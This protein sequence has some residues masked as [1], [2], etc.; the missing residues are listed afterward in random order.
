MHGVQDADGLGAAGDQFVPERVDGGLDGLGDERRAL[1]VEAAV[2]AI[3]SE[4]YAASQPGGRYSEE[5]LARAALTAALDAMTDALAHR[6]DWLLRRGSMAYS[7]I[8]LW[9]PS[10]CRRL[11][12]SG[13][14]LPSCV[15]A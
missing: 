2:G 3:E 7:S 11:T 5:G 6:G 15:S 13:M 14:S 4:V 10:A 12:A 8:T 9:K 1:A